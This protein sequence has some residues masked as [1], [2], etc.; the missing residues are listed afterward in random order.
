MRIGVL[1][2]LDQLVSGLERSGLVREELDLSG[3]GRGGT[4][5]EGLICT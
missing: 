2:A 3:V 4:Q 5:R 1:C